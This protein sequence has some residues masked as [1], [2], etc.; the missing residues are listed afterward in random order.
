MTNYDYIYGSKVTLQCQ[1]QVNPQLWAGHKDY[2]CYL[3]IIKKEPNFFKYW[4]KIRH[5]VTCVVNE[6]PDEVLEGDILKFVGTHKNAFLKE[7]QRAVSWSMGT[8]DIDHASK[9]GHG[10]QLVYLPF[11]TFCAKDQGFTFKAPE[12]SSSSDA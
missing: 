5:A 4:Y 10:K 2:D 12:Y 6:P 3:S 11:K 9:S 7:R 1:A 8:N